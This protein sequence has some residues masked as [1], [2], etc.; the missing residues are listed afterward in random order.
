VRLIWK[1]EL[2]YLLWLGRLD[3]EFVEVG[4]GINQN[5]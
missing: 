2:K 5:M 1:R 4:F 3:V